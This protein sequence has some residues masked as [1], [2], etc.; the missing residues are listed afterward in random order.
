LDR[1]LLREEPGGIGYLFDRTTGKVTHLT[2]EEM[3]EWRGRPGVSFLPLREGSPRLARSVPFCVWFELTLRCN[4]SCVHC[5]VDARAR[6]EIGELGFSQVARLLRQF[7]DFG[8]FEVRY[9]GGEPT[10]HPAFPEIVEETLR[11]GLFVSVSTN[12]VWGEA[13]GR[14]LARLPVGL[15]IVSLDGTREEH[16][17]LRPPGDTW[18]RTV[19]SIRRLVEAGRRVRI[20]TVLCE[21]NYRG[22]RMHVENL[23]QLGVEALTLVPVRPSGRAGTGAMF[24]SLCLSTGQYQ[25]VLEEV[26]RLREEYGFEI[27]TSYDFMAKGRMFNTPAHFAKRCVAGAEAA[28]VGPTGQLRACILLDDQKYA[29]GD[30]F[31]SDTALAELWADDAR[32]GIFRN[33]ESV[34]EICRACDHLGRDCFG[35][36]HVFRESSLSPDL[37]FCPLQSDGRDAKV[38]MAR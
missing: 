37:P 31:A 36:C 18:A 3:G 34:P 10:C 11:Q 7:A 32:W 2:R 4:I 30:L 20:N 22:L 25:E 13:R 35:V 33:P 14:R 6:P 15:Y 12:G 8:I 29:V 1:L 9:S 16:N 17:S 26:R 38:V 27:A 24:N 23:V 19:K 28:C 21:R 5:S